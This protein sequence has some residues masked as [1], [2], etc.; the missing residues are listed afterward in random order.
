MKAKTVALIEVIVLFALTLFLI[1]LVGSSAAAAWVRNVTYRAYLEYVVMLGVPLIVLLVS[2]RNLADYGISFAR[3]RYHLD[4]ALLAFIPFAVAGFVNSL[5]DDRS[6]SGALVLSLAWIAV[7][8][9]LGLLLRRKPTFGG[10]L[11]MAAMP[12]A[13][14]AA[15]PAAQATPGKAISALIFYVFFLGFGEELLF[16]GYIQSRLNVA[17]GK[18]FT[19]L[20]VHWGWGAVVSAVLFG[21]MHFLNVA[22]LAAG[23]W[24]LMPWWGVWTFFGGLAL[25]LVREKTGSIVAPSILHGLPQGIAWAFLGM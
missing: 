8:V 18:P 10:T 7:L 17:F 24:L 21:A 4:V 9:V 6:A 11:A 5:V 14:L 2:R 3:L 13:W 23:D 12:L 20:G 16:R 1:A 19:F 25:S 15:S 22:S